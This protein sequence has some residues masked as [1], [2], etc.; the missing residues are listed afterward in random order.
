MN[1]T[2]MVRTTCPK[3]VTFPRVGRQH[4]DP[5]FPESEAVEA[6][7]RCSVLCIQRVTLISI[8]RDGAGAADG[9]TDGGFLFLSQWMEAGRLS[10]QSKAVLTL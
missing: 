3:T 9:R 4:P 7:S 5:R 6:M 2:A 8:G 1:V 10:L